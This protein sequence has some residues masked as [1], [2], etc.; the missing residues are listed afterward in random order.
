MLRITKICDRCEAELASSDT[1]T[2]VQLQNTH[3]EKDL[4]IT[5]RDS[6]FSWYETPSTSGSPA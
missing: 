1:L 6:F 4:C 3:W 5:C 2:T